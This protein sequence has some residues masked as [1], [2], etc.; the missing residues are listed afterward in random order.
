MKA[1][2]SRP[3]NQ[4]GISL[5]IVL[6]LLLVTTLL[7]IAVLRGT[8]LEERMSANL[9]DRSLAFQAAESA[10]RRAEASV[11]AAVMGGTSIGLDCSTPGTSCP[12]LPANAYTGNE[13]GCSLGQPDCWVDDD[14]S[15]LTIAAGRPQY[16]IQYMGQRDSIDELG[17]GSSANANQYG[18]GGGVPLESVY[19][20]LARSND[21]ANGSARSIVVLQSNIA[22]K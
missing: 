15:T 21:P 1:P 11:Q 5:L 20:V 19:R 14:E 17:L 22:V 12:V 8:L 6:M 16:Y 18:G 3:G 2:T 9:Y 10:L 13:A 7:G 4:R